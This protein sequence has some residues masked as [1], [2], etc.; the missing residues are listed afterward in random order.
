MIL[1]AGYSTRLWPLTIDRAKP[2]IPFLGRPLVGYVA[3]Y[4]AGF[5]VSDVIVNLHHQ[6]E[7]VRRALGDGRRFGV[8][9]HY[10]EEPEILGTSGALDNARSLLGDRTFIVINGK[11]VTDIDLNAAYETHRRAGALATLVLRRNRARERFSVVET[12]AGWV[13]G[14]SGPPAPLASDNDETPLMFTGIQ[15]LE[16]GIFAYIP[17]KIFSHS[18]TDVYPRAIA[19]GERIAAHVAEGTWYELSTIQRYLSTSLAL[20]HR[21]GQDVQLGAGSILEPGADVHDSILWEG[22]TVETGG[23]VRRSILGAGVR[24]RRGEV[25]ENAAVVRAELVRGQERPAKALPGQMCGDNF[26][27]ML[28]E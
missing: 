6:P 23:R 10:V 11:I 28:P 14:F 3:E 24:V 22:V 4:L 5:G 8:R 16:P 15:F 27:V 2:A 19:R 17:P 20:M 13:T 18:T 1:A 12:R 25:I 26:V 7:S 9:L 21:E